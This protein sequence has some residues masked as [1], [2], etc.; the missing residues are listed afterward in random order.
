V[1]WQ[2]AVESAQ[3]LLGNRTTAITSLS[4]RFIKL[5]KPSSKSVCSILPIARL[6]YE[7]GPGCRP[8]ANSHR[9]T[10][11]AT[12]CENQEP[13]QPPADIQ[14]ILDVLGRRKKQGDAGT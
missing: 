2:A 9:F 12:R 7:L 11:A 10:V 13:P 14:A 8:A 5:T 4:K 3:F 6:F 1:V